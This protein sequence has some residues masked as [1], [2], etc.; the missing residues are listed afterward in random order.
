MTSLAPGEAPTELVCL[1]GMHR[2]G[3]SLLARVASLLGV[4]LGA[5][6]ATLDAARAESIEL[7]EKFRKWHRRRKAQEAADLD[8]PL[9]PLPDLDDED[10]EP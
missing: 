7:R 6:D 8:A 1:T 10:D 3:T 2:S 4:D 9:P 5:P